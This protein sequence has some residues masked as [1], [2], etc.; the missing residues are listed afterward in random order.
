VD[1]YL[2]NWHAN[3]Y[4]AFLREAI[5]KFG[6]DTRV[7]AAYGMKDLEGGLSTVEWCRQRNIKPISLSLFKLT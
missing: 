1:Y 2:D 3:N 4:P 5:A 7:T 6:Y